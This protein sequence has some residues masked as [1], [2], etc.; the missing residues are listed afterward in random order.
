M[1]GNAKWGGNVTNIMYG[2]VPFLFLRYIFIYMWLEKSLGNISQN[3]SS[4]C[5]WVVGLPVMIISLLVSFLYC[6]NHFI[7]CGAWVYIIRKENKY[8][9]PL[10][11][12][13]LWVGERA[14]ESAGW[15][16]PVWNGH[17]LMRS[18]LELRI[19]GQINWRIQVSCWNLAQENQKSDHTLSVKDA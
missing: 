11:Q 2:M 3:I 10:K 12:I 13:K 6:L 15:V 16:N 1:A 19:T 17:E 18:T 9:F 4:V 8:L 7:K 14:K 5:I